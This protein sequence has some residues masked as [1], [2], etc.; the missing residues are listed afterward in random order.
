[1]DKRI[2]NVEL[3]KSTNYCTLSWVFDG[4]DYSCTGEF[5]VDNDGNLHHVFF[6]PQNEEL[7]IVVPYFS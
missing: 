6:T 4:V 2:S 7:E 1:M 5:F 3:M